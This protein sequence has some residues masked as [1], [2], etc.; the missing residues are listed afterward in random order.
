MEQQPKARPLMFVV[1]IWPAHV[2]AEALHG[3]VEHVAHRRPVHFS[4]YEQLIEF[5]RS[6]LDKQ[7]KGDPS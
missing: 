7:A 1:Q 6:Q 2:R 4:T 5:I 3:C